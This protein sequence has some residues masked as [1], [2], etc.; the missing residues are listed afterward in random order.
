MKNGK[1]QIGFIGAGN[2]AQNAHIPAYLQRKDVEL[3]AVYDIHKQRTAEAAQ[4]YDMKCCS[5]MEEL[6]SLDYLDA[7]SI[8]TWNNGHAESAIAAAKAGKHILCEKPMSMTVAEAMAM[9]KAANESGKVFMMGFVYRFKPEPK[10]VNQMR[11]NGDF[12]DIYYARTTVLRRR[13]TPI[14]WF[15]DHAKSGGG[16]VIDIGVHVIDLT[17]FLMGKPKPVSLMAQ[18][19]YNKFGDFKTKGVKRWEAFDTDDTIYNV[20]DSAAGVINFENGKSINFDV[21]WAINGFAEMNA[22]LYGEKSGATLYPLT[23][24]GEN[25]DYLTNNTPVL[26]EENHFENEI[27]HFIDCIQESTQCISPAADGVAIQKILCGIYESG[28]SGEVIML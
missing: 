1:I 11:L 19:H 20:E 25:A 16:P 9:E 2:I 24:F 12:G 4:K 23:I 7:V 21:S 28:K 17:W 3:A 26:R 14:G 22:H 27:S 8:C 10:L 13:G 15:T 6:L 18:I 5:S